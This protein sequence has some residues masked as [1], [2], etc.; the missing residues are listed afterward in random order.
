[1]VGTE[2]DEFLWYVVISDFE[3]NLFLQNFLGTGMQKKEIE[4]E[5]RQVARQR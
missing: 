5:R 2:R 3:K 1:M 4:E